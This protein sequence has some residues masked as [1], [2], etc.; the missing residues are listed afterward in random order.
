MG[1]RKRR[2][3]NVHILTIEAH[4]TNRDAEQEEESNV[5]GVSRACMMIE[6]IGAAVGA[7]NIVHVTETRNGVGG[8]MCVTHLTN[9]YVVVDRAKLVA[10]KGDIGR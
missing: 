1:G 7:G 6:R 2:D 8:D 4:T 5:L 10:M 3:G 9:G